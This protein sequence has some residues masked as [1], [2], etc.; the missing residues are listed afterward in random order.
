MNRPTLIQ[1]ETKVLLKNLSGYWVQTPGFQVSE[2][3]SHSLKVQL[4]GNTFPPVSNSTNH[5][6]Q[7]LLRWPKFKEETLENAPA[8]SSQES[9]TPPTPAVSMEASSAS[10]ESLGWSSSSKASKC[11]PVR[12]AGEYHLHVSKPRWTESEFS[13]DSTSKRVLRTKTRLH[14]SCKKRN[15]DNCAGRTQSERKTLFVSRVL[16]DKVSRNGRQERECCYLLEAFV[17]PIQGR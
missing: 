10:V 3:N 2:K 5:N 13:F 7:R 8:S 4:P 16:H 17:F 9:S 14:V 15:T 6:S 12:H 11:Q 1:V